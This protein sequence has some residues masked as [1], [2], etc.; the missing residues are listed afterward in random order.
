[1]SI[2]DTL[3][4]AR[5]QAGLTVT[6]VSQRTCIRETIIRGIERGDYS[7]CGGDFYARGHIRSIARAVGADPEPLIREYDQTQGAPRA[8]SAADV[9]EPATPIKIRE[10]RRP[11]WSAAMVLA[12]AVL[13]GLVVYHV[14][15][16][17]RPAPTA[18]SGSSDS[19]HPGTTTHR[20]TARHPAHP[21]P[22]SSPAPPV[23]ANNVVIRLAATENCWVELT[24]ASGRQIYEGIV[25][26][27]TSRHWTETE[28]VS[29]MLG[30]PGGV[31]L[32]VNGRDPVPAGS[33]QPV[34]LSLGPGQKTAS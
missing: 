24:T 33:T 2:G 31:S 22:T 23:L 4:D 7:A 30:N 17:S 9:F 29:L 18:S 21:K 27:G 25:Y 11:N 5:R 6:Q 15:S 32:S 10:R 16:S 20:S 8:I 28:A 19:Q 12:L 13:V 14:V 3:A 34:T 1:V 26:A